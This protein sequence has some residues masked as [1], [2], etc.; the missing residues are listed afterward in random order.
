MFRT[1]LSGHITANSN[2]SKNQNGTTVE[3]NNNRKKLWTNKMVDARDP[4]L[5]TNIIFKI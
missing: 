2:K 5:S 4:K 1:K 3:T